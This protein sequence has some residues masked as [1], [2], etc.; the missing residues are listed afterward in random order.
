MVLNGSDTK[1]K[2]RRY[3]K[4]GTVSLDSRNIPLTEQM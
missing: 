4:E 1:N 2:V 3:A